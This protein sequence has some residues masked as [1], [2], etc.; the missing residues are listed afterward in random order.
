MS[1]GLLIFLFVLMPPIFLLFSEEFQGLPVNVRIFLT[2]VPQQALLLFGMILTA[3]FAEGGAGI[4]EMM[5]RLGL[6]ACGV[7]HVLYGAL[8]VLA[9]FPLTTMINV[10][11]YMIVSQFGINLS[12]PAVSELLS[13]CPWPGFIFIAFGA[14]IL[15]PLGEEIIFRRVIFCYA[16]RHVSILGASVISSGLFAAAHFNLRHFAGL[17]VLGLALQFLY[18][19]SRSLYPCIVLH[20]S[21]NFISIFGFLLLKMMKSGSWDFFS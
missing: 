2:V 18:L 19:R 9:V 15:A 14:L 21:Q 11:I 7:K 13:S 17:F 16:S 1:A 20:F 12:A 8:C 3:A 5:R 4:D 10:V 6:S